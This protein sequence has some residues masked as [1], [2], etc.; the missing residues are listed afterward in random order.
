MTDESNAPCEIDAILGIGVSTQM[1][2]QDEIDALAVRLIALRDQREQLDNQ[3]QAI[4]DRI[5]SS[6][7]EEVGDAVI[8]GTQ[9]AFVVSRNEQWKWDSKIIEALVPTV[10]VPDHVKV[11][12]TVDKRKFSAMDDTEKAP[13]LP[14]L[15]R[16]PGNPKIK[17]AL[18]G[19]L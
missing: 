12:Y 4:E 11:K 9:Y 16:K 3:I 6:T 13:W 2:P 18:K 17:T 5:W 15:E 10:P 19:Q 7:P 14:A 8:E 1:S